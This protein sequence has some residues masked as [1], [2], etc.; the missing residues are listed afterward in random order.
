MAGQPGCR[1]FIAAEPKARGAFAVTVW[2]RLYMAGFERERR[3][4]DDCRKARENGFRQGVNWSLI[5]LDEIDKE[6]GEALLTL[7]NQ[8]QSK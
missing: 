1:Q 2:D 4:I 5:K 8:E 7:F 3:F 6:A